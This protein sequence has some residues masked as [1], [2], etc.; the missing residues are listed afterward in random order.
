MDED[1][2]QALRSRNL[3]VLTVAD[4]GMLHRSVESSSAS[5]PE[6]FTD[7]TPLLLG[8]AYLM[9]ELFWLPSNDTALVN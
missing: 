2:V 3:D 1:F 4:V 7:C 5:T 8:K 6:T 9:Q